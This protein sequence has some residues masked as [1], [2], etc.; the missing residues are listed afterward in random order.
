M[1]RRDG[2]LEKYNIFHSLF[3]ACLKDGLIASQW[4]SIMCGAAMAPLKQAPLVSQDSCLHP[5]SSR[6]GWSRSHVEA[7]LLARGAGLG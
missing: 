5:R 6:S 4:W 1:A 2:A 3:I 7:Q